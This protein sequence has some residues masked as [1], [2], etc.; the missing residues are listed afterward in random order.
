VSDTQWLESSILSITHSCL[1]K[2]VS[3]GRYDLAS[4]LIRGIDSYARSLAIAHEVDIAFKVLD[5]LTTKC[6]DTLFSK[7]PENT[8]FESLEAVALADA[9]ASIPITIFLAYAE[10]LLQRA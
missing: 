5:D 1:A 8:E 4:L 2:N 9:M 7:K 10:A 6:A 3:D